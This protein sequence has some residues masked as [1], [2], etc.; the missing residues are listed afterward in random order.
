M[1]FVKRVA[2]GPPSRLRAGS[3]QPQDG[4]AVALAGAAH[5]PE[6]SDDGVDQPD[7]AFAVSVDPRLGVDP[8]KGH[9]SG[10]GVEGGL[11]NGDADHRRLAAAAADGGWG[12]GRRV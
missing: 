3:D 1:C 8:A 11:G 4:I 12:L 10:D 7:E 9:G 5:G 2:R 6:T